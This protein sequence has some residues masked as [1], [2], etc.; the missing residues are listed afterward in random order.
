[1]LSAQILLRTKHTLSDYLRDPSMK[2]V[3]PTSTSM[4]WRLAHNGCS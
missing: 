3:L 1:M 4:Y 2:P